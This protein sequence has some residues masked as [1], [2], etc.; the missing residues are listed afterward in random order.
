MAVG[1]YPCYLLIL[2][3]ILIII[4]YTSQLQ[5]SEILSLLRIKR[6]LNYPP[7][8]SSWN[9]DTDFCSYEA[10]PLLTVICYEESITQLHIAG[11]G[12]SPPLPRNFSMTS[13]FATLYQLPNLKVISFT[14]LGLW[15]PLPRKISRL[16]SLEIVN[17]S[18]NYL[19]GPIPK[20]ISKLINLQTLILDHNMFSGR[21]P[22][23]LGELPQLSVLSLKNN[24]LSGPL[25]DSFSSLKPLRVLA[26]SSNS[27]SGE[28]PDLS[29]LTNLQVLDLENNYFGPRFPSLGR[30]IVI[31]VLKKN[32]FS[33][34]L[35]A[36]VDTYYFLE[37][38]DISFNRFTGPFMPSLLCLPSI[39]YISIAGNRFTGMLSQSMSC[40]DELDYVDLSSNLLTGNLPTCLISVSKNALYSA[41]CLGMKDHSQRPFSFCQT[42]ALAVGIIPHKEHKVSTHKATLMIG[43][44][45]GIAGSICLGIVI[46]F[47][48]RRPS[49]NQG[50]NK[51]P[52]SS[53]EHASVGYSTQMFPDASCTLQT[54]KLG[55]LGISPYRSF[56]LEELEAATNN[57]DTSSFLGEGSHGQMYRG[58]L[59]DGSL[60]AIRCLK[61]KKAQNPQNFSRH[62]ELISKLRHHHLVSTL[63]HGFEYYLDD[64]SVSRLFIVFE[65]VSNGTLRSNI[66]DGVAGE[67]L[68]WTQRISAAIGVVK[69]IQFLHGGMV[70]GLFAND[71]KITNVM[72]DQHLVA[73]I[74]SYNLPILAD[75][76]KCEMLARNSSIVSKEPNQRSNHMDK[77]DIHDF[78]VI[79]LELI[80]GRPIMCNN[81]ADKIKN[82]LQENIA[83]DGT[84]RRQLVDPAISNACSDESLMTVAE[85]C[86]RSLSK[87]PT[88][89]PSIEDVLWNLQ[90]AA[91]VQESWRRYSHSSEEL[92]SL[93]SPPAL[94]CHHHLHLHNILIR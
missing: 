9:A 13:L 1:S 5:P 21:I 18:T 92:Q 76:M 84:V 47:V 87:E 86:L 94:S 27:L 65:F 49:R 14:S 15:G 67:K 53:S 78:G 64:S 3:M 69:G 71:L 6:L 11:N 7:V 24:S 74:S 63:G 89:R 77:I 23:L 16:S 85:I 43:V 60:V 52:R 44:I 62:I 59:Q 20:Q 38:L 93:P 37:H 32:K 36:E 72:L 48:L 25:P 46:F 54:M 10:N 12:T 68:T 70:P 73:K 56:S 58:E 40:N 2:S 75:D 51:H 19:Y 34:G 26:L 22:D 29:S 82:L 35:P 83:S 39:H 80:T 61:L 42:Q 90:F 8:L 91:Q 88:Q 79:L 45:G 57:F 33:G 17:M 41:N 30:K 66:S 55:A 81:E 31:L 28:L 50:L 4:P